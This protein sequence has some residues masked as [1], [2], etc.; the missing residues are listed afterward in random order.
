MMLASRDQICVEV[1]LRAMRSLDTKLE[2]VPGVKCDG[3]MM[4]DWVAIFC[5]VIFGGEGKG[6]GNGGMCWR[7]CVMLGWAWDDR[8]SRRHRE[9]RTSG[10][11][12]SV[13]EQHVCMIMLKCSTW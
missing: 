5:G 10:G 6:M 4:A 9:D 1:M 13:M 2:V 12:K 11:T 7:V 8:H 3:K